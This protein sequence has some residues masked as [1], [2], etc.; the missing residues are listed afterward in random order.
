MLDGGACGDRM[1]GFS[2]DDIMLGQGGFDKFEGRLGFDWASW[3][4]EDHGVSVDMNRREFV[5][6]PQALGGDAIR[7]F[8]IETE[9]ASG[10]AFS[11]LHPGHQRRHGRHLQRAQQRQPDLRPCRLL[12]GWPGGVLRRQH[13]VRRRAAATSSQGRGGNDI[14]DGD[15]RL[16]VELTSRE[17]GGQIIREILYDQA[18]GPT[19]DPVTGAVLTAGDIDTAVFTDVSA[20]LSDRVCH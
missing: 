2:G 12:P 20:N 9:A 14:I 5:D 10:S 4:N 7:D 16:H 1:Q 13:P 3:E 6:Q 11:R 18:V 17:A 8:F 15:A 19:F